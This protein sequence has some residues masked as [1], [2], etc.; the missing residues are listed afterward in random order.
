[1]SYTRKEILQSGA[2]QIDGM[3]ASEEHIHDRSLSEGLIRFFKYENVQSIIDLGAG[4]GNYT[5]AFRKSGLFSNCYDGNPNTQK[6]SDGRCGIIDLSKEVKLMPHEWTLCLEVGE[7]V[8]AEYEDILVQNMDRVNTKGVILS[9]AVE[10][11]GGY[12]HINCKNND[13]IK[14]KFASL[15]YINDEQLETDLRDVSSL[16][17]FKETVM[18]FRKDSSFEEINTTNEGEDLLHYDL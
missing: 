16:S 14:E 4:M 1:M 8:P 6:L 15:G 17:W 11:Q 2:W 13:Y 3:D 7:H 10:G 9:W 5:D 12:G 18:V